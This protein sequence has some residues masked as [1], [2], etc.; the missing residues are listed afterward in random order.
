MYSTDWNYHLISFRRHPKS[1]ALRNYSSK[2]GKIIKIINSP[3]VTVFCAKNSSKI[4]NTRR[5]T[6]RKHKDHQK[7]MTESE[8]YE[9]VKAMDNETSDINIQNET[10]RSTRYCC[11]GDTM[12]DVD[13]EQQRILHTEEPFINER[14]YS[15]NFCCF[16][17]KYHISNHKNYQNKSIF[18][19][20]TETQTDCTDQHFNPEDTRLKICRY[21]YIPSEYYPNRNMQRDCCLIPKRAARL[22]ENSVPA[23]VHQ[24]REIERSGSNGFQK[25]ITSAFAT[26]VDGYSSKLKYCDRCGNF[27]GKGS[28]TSTIQKCTMSKASIFV[29]SGGS[30][31]D[32][33]DFSLASARCKI[34]MH[35]AQH[36]RTMVLVEERDERPN[37]SNSEKTADTWRSHA[38]EIARASRS[39]QF[40]WEKTKDF[41]RGMDSKWKRDSIEID[42]Q[43]SDYKWESR[44]ATVDSS[45]GARTNM[46][47]K[48]Q[49]D[50]TR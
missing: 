37:K 40:S 39:D 6:K 11:H 34:D 38:R 23:K 21:S 28:S 8:G 47:F 41:V 45:V 26:E 31:V 48:E 3:T 46:D 20:N 35:P 50:P 42:A 2:K 32:L 16:N 19:F 1:F 10:M 14:K 13:K 43:Q 36:G 24:R 4:K 7:T 15:A 30:M 44:I 9:I 27:D 33:H 25:N 22:F 5:S 49:R 17:D 29:E 12:I 18:N